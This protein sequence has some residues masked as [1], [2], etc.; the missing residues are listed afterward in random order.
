LSHD[1]GI[2]RV[3][4]QNTGAGAV[5]VLRAVLTQLRLLRPSKVAVFTPYVPDLTAGVA[6]CVS[7]DGHTVV[8]S[9]G[10]GIVKNLDIGQVTPEE[11]VKFVESQMAGID[12]DCVFLSCTNWRAI[13]AIEPLK[14]KM[15]L[16]VISSNQAAIDAVVAFRKP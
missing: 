1:D 16:P 10:M 11:I 13:E 5:T 2:G 12:A 14:E 7:E 4:E 15:R 3:I 9:V 6:R 8:K